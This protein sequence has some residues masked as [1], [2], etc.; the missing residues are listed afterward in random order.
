MLEIPFVDDVTF[1]FPAKLKGILPEAKDIPERFWQSNNL[2]HNAAQVLF[3][4]GGEAF[5]ERFIMESK[6]SREDFDKAI[7][8][9]HTCLS[10]FEPKHEHKIAGVAY[11]MS[12]WFDIKQNPEFKSKGPQ[13]RLT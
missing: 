7:R 11:M 10:S 13:L 9:I 1:A 2:Y 8:A 4:F 3:G 6:L 12:E 5:N